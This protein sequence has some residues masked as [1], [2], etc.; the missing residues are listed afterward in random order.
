MLIEQYIENVKLRFKWRRLISAAVKDAR[1]E[2]FA[3]KERGEGRAQN[4]KT[5]PTGEAAVKNISGIKSVR[6]LPRKNGKA[7]YV[8]DPEKW[9]AVID[10]VYAE[11]ET[12]S[13]F[14]AQ[15][16]HML[17]DKHINADVVAGLMGVS[18]QAFYQRQ[19]RFL[20]D[21]AFLAMHEGLLKK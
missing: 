21:A 5:D 20:I 19:Q 7:V 1:A 12:K 15:A 11:Y 10:A 6:I 4:K 16:M 8:Q 2:M 13:P 9:L 14:V 17:Y 18:R 3:K